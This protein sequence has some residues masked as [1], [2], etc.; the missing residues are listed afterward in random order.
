M[1]IIRITD[2][3][4]DP[5]PSCGELLIRLKMTG[6]ALLARLDVSGFGWQEMLLAK[7]SAAGTLPYGAMYAYEESIRLQWQGAQSGR[8]LRRRAWPHY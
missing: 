1:R 6:R 7:A 8:K 4:V 5:L 3:S 2:F